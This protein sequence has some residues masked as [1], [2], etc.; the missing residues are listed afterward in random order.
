[1]LTQGD[2]YPLHQTPEPIAY[3]GAN[4]N[5]YDRFFFNGY[6]PAGDVFFAVAMGVYPYLNVLD[7]AFSVVVDGVQHNVYGSKVMHLERLDTNVGVLSVEIVKP[8]VEHRIICD[9]PDNGIAAD[10]VFVARMP[11]HEEPRFTRRTG[12][13]VTMDVTRMMQNGNWSG[14]IEVKGKRIEISA[15]EFCG[16]RD[17]SWG[18]R[19]IGTADAQPNP[20]SSEFQFY[21]LWAPL[22]FDKF[23]THY[24][25]NDDASGE[26]WNTNGVIIPDF[27]LGEAETM[28]QVGS[29]LKFLVGTRFASGAEIS[30]KK[31][32]GEQVSLTLSPK[33]NFYM[34][35][36]GYGHE[37]FSHGSYHGES[38]TGYDEFVT[39]EV[40]PDN[41]HIQAFCDVV[42]SSDAGEQRG[43]GVLEQLIVGPHAP[44]GF[45]EMM[46]FAP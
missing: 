19:S 36:I 46:D 22:N 34:K 12:S 39:A 7:G 30:F 1:M 17:R 33:W 28:K 45:T 40:S 42:Y 35:G 32:S 14:W 25:V 5:F 3:V 21:W 4:R 8:M 41:I 13:Q 44:S 6:N 16:T 43:W 24:F 2:D 23:S 31:S 9:D 27:G 11:A 10:L 26:P 18:I 29:E 38:E 20:V 37:H 15:N